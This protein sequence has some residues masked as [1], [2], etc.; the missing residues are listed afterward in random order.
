VCVCVCVCECV[1][2]RVRTCA[3]IRVWYRPKQTLLILSRPRSQGIPSYQNFILDI[4][5]THMHYT[6]IIIDLVL[7]KNN[8]LP[9]FCTPIPPPANSASPFRN[10]SDC[11]LPA[12][13]ACMSAGCHNPVLGASAQHTTNTNIMCSNKSVSYHS[14]VNCSKTNTDVS[15]QSPVKVSTDGSHMAR[16]STIEESLEKS[17][18]KQWVSYYEEN[19]RSVWDPLM[20]N[21]NTIDNR[22]VTYR[23]DD[24]E[25]NIN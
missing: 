15:P 6:C 1:C 11:S 16:S 13:P 18:L 20:P 4:F 8:L 5:R 2:A 14:D 22:D 9:Y 23:G 12:S 17:P 7:I 19:Q 25:T 3:C 24:F 10:T 21:N